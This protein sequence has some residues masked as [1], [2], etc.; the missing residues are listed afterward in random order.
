MKRTCACKPNAINCLSGKEWMK[1]QIGLWEFNYEKR[2]VRDRKLHPATFPISLARR[3]V[4]SFTHIGDTVVDPFVGSGTTLVACD[5]AGRTG[6]GFDLKKEYCELAA[7]RTKQ[8]VINDN[9]LNISSHLDPES[10][11]LAFTSPPY[12]NMLNRKR[13]N[14]SRRSD[15]RKNEQYDEV[16]QYSQDPEDLGTMT[17]EKWAEEMKK[18]IHGMLPALAPK[19]HVVINVNDLWMDDRRVMLSDMLIDALKSDILEFRN[20]IIWDKRNL[21][22]GA[23]IFGYPSNYITMGATYEYILHFRKKP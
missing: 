20:Q 23:G 15:E 8:K 10:V 21:V 7:T 5:D 6:I 13:K 22:N 19:G 4:E 14:K 1:A 2:D 12:A 11:A 17:P 18:I 16:E 9:S 3:V